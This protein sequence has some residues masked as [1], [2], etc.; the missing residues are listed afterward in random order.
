MSGRLRSWGLIGI[1]LIAGVSISYG[2]T[3]YAFRDNRF[4][5]PVDE[6]REFT[7]V[8]GAIKANYVE[9]VED[10]KL[11]QE[12]ISGMLAG[13]DPH[14]AFLDGDAYRD[15]QIGTQGE[16]GGLGIEVGSEDGAIKVIAPIDDTPAA[17]AGIRAGDLIIKIDDKFTRGMSLA[18]AIKL[19]RGKPQTP[20]AL[21]LARKG[22]ALP[23]EV[24]IIRD[25]I[26]VQSVKAH[27]IEPGYGFVRITQFQD[28]TTEDLVKQITEL[29]KS[30][31][32]KGL[33]LDLRNDPGGVLNGAVGVSAVFLPRDATVV[34][35]EGRTEDAHRRFVAAPSDYLRGGSDDPLA[36]L[37]SE[38]KTVP[39]VVLVNGASASASEIVAGALQDHKRAELIGTQTFGKGSV[40]SVIQIRNDRDNPAAI[41]LTTARYFTPNGRSIQAQ[42]IVPDL[43]V[44]DTAEGNFA[45]LSVREADMAHH[46]VNNTA[47][48]AGGDKGAEKAP[49]DKA[50][51]EPEAHAP[52]T[53]HRYEFGSA[54]DFQLQ[55][56]MHFFK[57]IPVETAKPHDKVA[58]SE[59]HD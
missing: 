40:Q 48:A 5:I 16:F 24:K 57:G 50:A 44:D 51:P 52:L 4:P 28:R 38:V 33:V 23:I 18:D 11:M 58:A 29:Y 7:D 39:L 35:T 37:P 41:K 59:S 30:G 6:I 8:F 32:L 31:P 12:A 19:M 1:G 17:R 56:A 34:S 49:A 13:L 47:N 25:I 14:S 53:V 26:R 20:I 36:H 9:P 3:A 54:E 45:G 27:L 22:E 43:L 2:V 10:K 46:L 15:L 55:Q 21:T 42:G